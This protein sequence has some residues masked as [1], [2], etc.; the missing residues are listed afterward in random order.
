MQYAQ[1]LLLEGG[2][3]GELATCNL[4]GSRHLRCL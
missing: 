4:A 3:S 2:G 1:F